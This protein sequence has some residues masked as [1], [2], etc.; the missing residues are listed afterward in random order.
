M[1]NSND[2]KMAKASAVGLGACT[3]FYLIVGNIGY[4]LNGYGV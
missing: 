4:A 3:L 2:Q 1:R